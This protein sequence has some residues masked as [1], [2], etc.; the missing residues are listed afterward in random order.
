MAWIGI[1]IQ[2]IPIVIKL[3]QAIESILGSGTG[4]QKKAYVLNTVR[5]LVDGAGDFTGQPETWD[6]IEA[7]IN[8]LID[9]A[10]LF[11]FPKED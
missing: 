6:K 7:A 1:V 11:L 3:M 4:D 10:V 5:A 2:L 9:I 8:P